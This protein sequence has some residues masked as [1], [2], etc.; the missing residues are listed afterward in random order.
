MADCPYKT[1]GLPEIRAGV[2]QNVITPPIGTS[3]AGYFHDRVSER[4]LDDLYCH[5]LVVESAGERIVLVSCDVICMPRA[6]ADPAKAL[7]EQQTGIPG[8]HVLICCTHTHTGPEMRR[9]RL[10]PWNDEYLDALPGKIA[11]TVKEACDGMFDALMFPGR[12]C[13]PDLGTIRLGRKKDGSEVFSKSDVIGP[14]REIDPE[15]LAMLIRDKKGELRGVV[16]NYANHGDVT[17]GGGGRHL[18]ADWFGDVA[19]TIAA[20][21]GEQAVTV[22]LNGCCG[23]INHNYW[24]TTRHPTGGPVKA[25]QI[26]RAVAGVAMNA[27]EKGEPLETGVCGAILRE[28]EIP[29]YTREETLRAEIEELRGKDS[30]SDFERYLVK[31]FDEWP[32]DSEVASVPLQ[33]MRLGDLAFVGLPGEIFTDW[34]KEIKHWSPAR[35]TF[36]AELAND[37]FGYIP[38]TD[39]AHRGAYGAKPLLSRML[40]A[41]GGRQMADSIQVMLWELWGAEKE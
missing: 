7:I 40:C 2:A 9:A 5:A 26:G 36:I 17:G 10:I 30:P 15:V 20:V 18:S 3:M 16:V 31:R 19:R 22:F 27:G 13:E 33:V 39:Q 4:V 1:E 6:I 35:F 8:S 32:H 11:A 29:Y 24:R 14:A 25:T 34:G 38:N 21:Y 41:D 37:W 12:Q 23:D 28:V